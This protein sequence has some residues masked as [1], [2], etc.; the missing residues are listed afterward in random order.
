MI[1]LDCPSN[2]T[3]YDTSFT[4]K[5][6]E[7]KMGLCLDL[8]LIYGLASKTFKSEIIEYYN[9]HWRAK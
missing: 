2:N 8:D 6:S 1:T 7:S 4:I 9:K 5:T 3:S